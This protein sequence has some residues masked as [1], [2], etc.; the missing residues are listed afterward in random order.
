MLITAKA[1][2]VPES[3]FVVDIEDA[4]DVYSAI[5]QHC[6]VSYINS[7]THTVTRR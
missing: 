1:S 2:E 3:E 7:A 5:D 6:N 4:I